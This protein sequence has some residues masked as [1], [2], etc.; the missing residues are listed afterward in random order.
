MASPLGSDRP[1]GGAPMEEPF[2]LPS[3]PP[4]PG[5][6]IVDCPGC[7]VTYDDGEEMVECEAC[8][9]WAHVSCLKARFADKLNLDQYVCPSCQTAKNERNSAGKKSAEH[10]AADDSARRNNNAQ[11]GGADDQNNNDHAGAR[12]KHMQNKGSIPGRRFFKVQQKMGISDEELVRR[13]RAFFAKGAPCFIK[14]GLW[15][16]RALEPKLLGERRDAFLRTLDDEA[17]AWQEKRREEAE[18]RQQERAERARLRDMRTPYSMR[19]EACQRFD[20]EE[21]ERREEEEAARRA[22]AGEDE[23]MEDEQEEQVV[24]EEQRRLDEEQRKLQEQQEEEEKQRRPEERRKRRQPQQQKEKEKEKAEKEKEKREEEKKVEKTEKREDENKVDSAS[25]GNAHGD[26]EKAAASEPKTNGAPS[27]GEAVMEDVPAS[28]QVK[29]AGDKKMPSSPGP[30]DSPVDVLQS[31][32]DVPHSP[33]T[34]HGAS[35]RQGDGG[36]GVTSPKPAEKPKEDA[37]DA[38]ANIKEPS[39]ANSAAAASPAPRSAAKK[40][41]EKMASPAPAAP[42]PAREEGAATTPV[43]QRK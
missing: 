26:K 9:V 5:G 21:E 6:W 1:Y 42:S 40:A 19:L 10:D 39:R 43:R 2:H 23:Q 25:N 22:E 34:P 24:D 36:E 3:P 20:E 16:A 28:E 30:Q 38:T 4:S 11:G 14:A 12:A 7:G 29:A 8:N 32:A 33:S 15:N 41:M 35:E 27:N 18:K 31:P 17:E 37:A 13:Q